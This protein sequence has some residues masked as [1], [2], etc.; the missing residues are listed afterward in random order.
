MEAALGRIMSA[1]EITE[2]QL[3]LNSFVEQVPLDHKRARP[4][5]AA[6]TEEYNYTAK[7]ARTSVTSHAYVNVGKQYEC[8]IVPAQPLKEDEK[9]GE[10]H[11][12]VMNRAGLTAVMRLMLPDRPSQ[13]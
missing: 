11:V 9:Q 5:I 1:A 2:D 4:C 6:T 10:R 8:S 3:K 12:A 7:H 13:G